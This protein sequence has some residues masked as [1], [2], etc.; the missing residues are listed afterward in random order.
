METT[1]E[2]FQLLFALADR[3]GD[4]LLSVQ[5]V[6]QLFDQILISAQIDPVNEYQGLAPAF[7]GDLNTTINLQQFIAS[8]N[9]WWQNL[10][11]N[12]ERQPNALFILTYISVL[13]DQ[14]GMAS[15]RQV[16][17]R[18]VQAINNMEFETAYANPVNNLSTLPIAQEVDV[19]QLHHSTDNIP[20]ANVVSLDEPVA[21]PP[22][23]PETKVE[24]PVCAICIEPLTS[25][26]EYGAKT[27]EAE[28]LPCVH[29]FHHDCLNEMRRIGSNI[30]PMCRAPFPFQGGRKKKRRRK[31][32][33]KK[34]K[35]KGKKRTRRMLNHKKRKSRKKK[36]KKRSTKRNKKQNSKKKQRKTAKSKK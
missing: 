11:Q 7:T 8:M 18:I 19:T 4:G 20:I 2:R 13:T 6:K 23:P 15:A 9:T 27:N 35:Q 36:K 33:K 31:T 26:S 21:P 14:R 30:C 34:L 10:S 16:A 28:T 1:N 29:T 24:Q 5:E 17:D 3:N 32:N 12:V 22:P 25:D